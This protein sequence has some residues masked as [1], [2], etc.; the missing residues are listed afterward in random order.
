[1][2]FISQYFYVSNRKFQF[3]FGFAVE[4]LLLNYYA[5]AVFDITY[6]IPISVRGEKYAVFPEDIKLYVHIRSF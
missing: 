1:M 5:G 6:V 2:A 4:E 3:Q